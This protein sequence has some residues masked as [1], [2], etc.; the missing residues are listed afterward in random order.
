MEK[1]SWS[2]DSLVLIFSII[3]IAQLISPEMPFTDISGFITARG[4]TVCQTVM[5]GTHS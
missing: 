2:F 4:Q 5:M 3:V 1:R